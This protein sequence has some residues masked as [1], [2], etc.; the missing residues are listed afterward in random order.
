MY[1]VGSRSKLFDLVLDR[2]L[3]LF[4]FGEPRRIRGRM[5][6]A[7]FNLAFQSLMTAFQFGEVVLQ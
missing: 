5:K 1:G 2:E 3:F 4:Q 6:P 7:L